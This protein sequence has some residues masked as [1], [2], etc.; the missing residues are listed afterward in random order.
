MSIVVKFH[1]AFGLP[2]P[3]Y[4]TLQSPDVIR[5]RMRLIRE[6]YEEAM[7]ELEQLLYV[8]TVEQ[9]DNGLKRLLKELSDLRYVVE[10]AAVTFGLPI[11]AAY[12][13]VH[14]SNMSKLGSDGRPIYRE[15]GKVL[16]GPNYFDPDMTKFI[17]TIEGSTE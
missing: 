3:P 14:R 7:A 8:Q 12:M 9:R 17:H 2:A 1:R 5:L 11:D 15:D 16:K 13:E 4:P 10:G 6:E